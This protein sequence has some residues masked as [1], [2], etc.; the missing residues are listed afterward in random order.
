MIFATPRPSATIWGMA[1]RIPAGWT[2]AEVALLGTAEDRIIA[3]H[4][5]RTKGN[6]QLTRYKLGIKA[7]VVRNYRR[8]DRTEQDRVK[9]A[10]GGK[11]LQAMSAAEYLK[12][13]REAVRV[14]SR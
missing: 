3:K 9:E 1:R 8:D 12:A 5:G 10:V 14:T 7:S 4:L 6:V 2:A 11:P 13:A